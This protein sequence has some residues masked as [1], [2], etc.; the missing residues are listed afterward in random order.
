MLLAAVDGNA[1]SFAQLKHGMELGVLSKLGK[2][3][4]VAFADAVANAWSAAVPGLLRS[5]AA[6][7]FEQYLQ[8]F[9]SRRAVVEQTTAQGLQELRWRTTLMLQATFGDQRTEAY[10]SPSFRVE[11]TRKVPWFASPEV[12]KEA[13]EEKPIGL[14]KKS[15][16]QGGWVG[17]KMA[18]QLAH[19]KGGNRCMYCAGSWKLAPRLFWPKELGGTETLSNLGSA[20]ECCREMADALGPRRWGEVLAMQPEEA[21][22]V[23]WTAQKKANMQSMDFLQ[24]QAPM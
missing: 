8:G 24:N 5:S 21:A 20:C 1:P 16:K 9:E 2:Y 13:F 7:H 12:V 18:T 3:G 22:E 23:W 6:L 11:G 17:S 15:Q 19:E 10:S 14:K 4:R